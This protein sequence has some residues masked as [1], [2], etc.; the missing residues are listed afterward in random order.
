[1]GAGGCVLGVMM[2]L[3]CDIMASRMS[4]S[5]QEH[6]SNPLPVTREDLKTLAY[7][8]GGVSEEA[9]TL[10]ALQP[11]GPK[12]QVQ[13]RSGRQQ[14]GSSRMDEVRGVPPNWTGLEATAEQQPS[15]VEERELGKAA[16]PRRPEVSAERWRG[17][18]LRQRAG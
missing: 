12:K 2:S 11:P 6:P 17:K 8:L 14:G 15:G 5:L 18:H 9:G 1:M 16:A 13:E 7:G 10:A 4:P 3:L